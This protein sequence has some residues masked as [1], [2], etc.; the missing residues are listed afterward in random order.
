MKLYVVRE[1]LKMIH[2]LE[3]VARRVTC[4]SLSLPVFT[5]LASYQLNVLIFTRT[6][7]VCAF[8]IPVLCSYGS[9]SLL[10]VILV[11]GFK[12]VPEILFCCRRNLE[13]R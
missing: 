8:V 2:V 6:S 9:K 3:A 1:E 5:T 13:R 7:C 11:D 12:Y 10:L 4:K